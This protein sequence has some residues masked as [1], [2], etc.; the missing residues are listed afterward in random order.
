MLRSWMEVRGFPAGPEEEAWGLLLEVSF[1][2]PPFFWVSMWLSI[3]FYFF[4]PLYFFIFEGLGLLKK[5]GALWEEAQKLEMEAQ[6]LEACG[7]EKMEVAMAGSE[8]ECFYGFPRGAMSHSSMS[9]APPPPKKVCHIPSATISHLPPWESQEPKAPGPAEQA[10]ESTSLTAPL[11]L[12]GEIPANMQLLHIQLGA[13]REFIDVRLR[14]AGRA[15][16]PPMPPFVHTCIEY[17]WE[18]GRCALSA[19]G[20]FSILILSDATKRVT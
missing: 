12:E 19:T 10:L 17:T 15:C 18:W 1:Y 8:V 3:T 16:Q 7:L 4:L 13:L 14:V 5:A 6:C 11:V 2:F 20:P 9:S